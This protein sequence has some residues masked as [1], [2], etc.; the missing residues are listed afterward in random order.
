MSESRQRHRK[1]G[2]GDF[3][4]AFSTT[5]ISRAFGVSGRLVQI[6]IT[7]GWLQAHDISLVPSKHRYRIKPCY[8]IDFCKTIECEPPR[9]ITEA[10]FITRAVEAL[11]ATDAVTIHNVPELRKVIAGAM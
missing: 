2:S 5:E 6:W 9:L 8:V 3:A 1:T 10:L 7:E 11:E 4:R